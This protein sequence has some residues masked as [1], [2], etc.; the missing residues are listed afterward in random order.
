[1]HVIK[2]NYCPEESLLYP[3]VLRSS[4]AAVA[5]P[6]VILGSILEETHRTKCKQQYYSEDEVL[7]VGMSTTSD[8]NVHHLQQGTMGIYPQ[9]YAQ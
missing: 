8:Y 2:D 5:S 4:I 6:R 9:L 3:V 1:M 7:L